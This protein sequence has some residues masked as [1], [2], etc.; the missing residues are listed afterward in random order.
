[1]PPPSPVVEPCAIVRFLQV[2][3]DAPCYGRYFYEAA[4]IER[5]AGRAVGPVMIR[6]LLMPNVDSSEIV[7]VRLT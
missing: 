3:G 5:D 4:T 7:P 2:W 1:M 6:F